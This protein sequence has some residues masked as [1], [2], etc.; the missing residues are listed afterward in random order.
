MGEVRDR[1]KVSFE[2]D[3]ESGEVSVYA[4]D[5]KDISY[6]LAAAM[7]HVDGMSTM[8]EIARQMSH[9]MRQGIDKEIN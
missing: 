3:F 9:A 8:M 5:D 4:D 2:I 7:A 1:V 6:V